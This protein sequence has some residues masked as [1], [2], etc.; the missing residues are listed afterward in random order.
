ML[1]IWFIFKKGITLYDSNNSNFINIALS[2]IVGKP[3][4]TTN[5]TPKKEILF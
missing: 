1:L 4:T 3:K 5:I 2:L